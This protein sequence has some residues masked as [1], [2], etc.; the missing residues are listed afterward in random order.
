MPLENMPLDARIANMF[1]S[2]MRYIGKTI[3]PS[4]L[5]VFYP[6]LPSNFPKTIEVTCALLFI[7]ISV[8]IIFYIGRRRR[9]IIMGWLWFVGTLVPTIGLVQSGAQAMA[10]RYMYI[11]MIG[12]LIIVAWTVKDFVANRP[13]WKIVTAVLAAVVLSSAIILTRMQVKHWQ[14]SLTLFEYTLKVTEN[15]AIAEN[16]Y[17]CALFETGKI[18]EAVLHLSKAVKISPEFS[19]A[20]NNLGQILL[21]QDKLNEA[22]EC[23]NELIKQKHDSAQVYY[24]LAAAMSMQNKYDD[25]IKYLD[26][27]LTL[28]PEYPDAHSRMG[29]ALLAAGRI[30]EAVLHLNEALQINP[31]KAQ[32]YADL[33]SAYTQLG[34]FNL[35][36][37]NWTRALELKPDSINVLNNI[38]W[39]LA[40][41]DDVS[42]QNA[43]KAIEFARQACELTKYSQPSVLDTLAVSYAAA[44]RFN[45]AVTTAEQAVNAAKACGQ[46]NLISEIQNRIELYKAGHRYIQK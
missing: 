20:R 4:R 42:I 6:P 39:L 44:G 2:Y 35:A 37:Q 3:W 12:L 11:P 23:F 29:S 1:I 24:H 18:D 9:Y 13:R 21:K 27:V 45:D 10:N 5:A 41:V 25:A 8:F 7:L 32:V 36:I 16:S 43:D 19:E 26:K 33:G 30:D 22:I 28:T 38:A 14:S 46:E 31:D 34:K 15:N 40:T 17:G